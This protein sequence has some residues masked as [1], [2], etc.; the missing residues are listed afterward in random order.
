MLFFCSRRTNSRKK[1]KH[2]K[3]S[4]DRT[5]HFES[6]S[7]AK[8]SV[9]VQSPTLCIERLAAADLRC[10]CEVCTRPQPDAEGQADCHG[11]LPMPRADALGHSENLF[12]A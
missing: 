4:A 9:E 11:E 10:A 5:A 8:L 7:S 2:W 1:L 6:C 12:P 3:Q